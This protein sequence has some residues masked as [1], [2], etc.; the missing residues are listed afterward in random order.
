MKVLGQNTTGGGGGQWPHSLFRI[1]PM[2][3]LKRLIIMLIFRIR[4]TSSYCIDNRNIL[5][6]GKNRNLK[7]IQFLLIPFS[8]QL[9]GENLWYSKFRVFD[10]KEF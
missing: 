10:L 7:G 4:R 5:V 9:G 8:L 2:L 1:K 6:S 3:N